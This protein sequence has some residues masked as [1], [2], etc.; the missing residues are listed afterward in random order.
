MRSLS[1]RLFMSPIFKMATLF[2]VVML[3]T[4]CGFKLRGMVDVASHLQQLSVQSPDNYG[5][6][7]RRLNRTLESNNIKIIASAPYVLRIT[8]NLDENKIASFTGNARAA[9]YRLIKQVKFQLENS[10]GLLLLGPFDAMSE[11]VYLYSS[12]NKTASDSEERL[13]REE[14]ERDIITQITQRLQVMTNEKIDVAEANARKKQA[15]AEK[16]KQLEAQKNVKP[17]PKRNAIKLAP[18][19][20]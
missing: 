16:A 19:N 18:P 12:S 7:N 9:Q 1:K 11:R 4:A 8:E 13:I 20:L 14:L 17:M 15:E 5:V 3:L 10:E 2:S 6:F